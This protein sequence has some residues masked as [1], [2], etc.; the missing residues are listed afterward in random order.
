MKKVLANHDYYEMKRVSL[1]AGEEEID[2]GTPHTMEGKY[3]N[4]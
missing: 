1:G 4:M 2:I 3:T